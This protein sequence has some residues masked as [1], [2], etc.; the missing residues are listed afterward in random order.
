MKFNIKNLKIGGFLLNTQNTILSAAFILAVTTGLN[1][2]LGFLKGRLLA[3]YFGVSANLTIFYTADRI[4]FLIYS[5]LVIG[6][7]STVFI[8]VFASILKHDKDKAFKTASAIITATLVFF[9]VLGGAVFALAPLIIRGLAVG[10]FTE[11]E[12]ALGTNLMRIMLAAQLILVAGSLITSVL[13]SFKIFLLPALAPLLY[14]IGMIVGIVF[15]SPKFGIYGPALGVVIGATLHFFIQLPALPRTSFK[16]IPNLNLRDKG[17]REIATLIPPRI[18]NVFLANTVDTI[19][20]S[21]AILVSAP[22]VIFLKFATQLQTFPVNLFGISI[23]SA[24]LPTL[25][26][27]SDKDNMEKFKDTFL[28]SLHQMMF[29]V[30]PLGMILLILRIPVV[31]LVYGVSNFPWEATLKTAYSLAFFSVSIF[32]QSGNYLITR[33]FYALKDTR[34]PV[35]VSICTAVVNIGLSLIFVIGF[36]LEVWAI[37]LSYSITSILDMAI[38]TYLLGKK[39]G[40]FNTAKLFIPFIK[41]SYATLLMGFT[42]YFPIKLLDNIVFDTA[43]TLNLLILTGIAGICGVSTYIIFTKLLNVYEI[44]LFYRFVAKFNPF[45]TRVAKL[46]VAQV[47]EV[48]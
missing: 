41:I 28:T 31:R 46:G 44:H 19:N 4:P 32:S 16:F 11:S 9:L 39:V 48:E 15:L 34:T 24:S 18:L 13:Q 47:E 30:M 21:L 36:K 33:A 26:A 12:I 38:Q 5:V 1:A 10:K 45:K 17:I 29:L 3:Q 22:S 40:G 37:A 42:L 20:N 8:P 43:H 2:G 35:V 25:S 23:S 7:I 27:L 14:N 6:A